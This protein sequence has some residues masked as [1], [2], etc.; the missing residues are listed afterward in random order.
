MS[1]FDEQQF[2]A[3]KVEP[4]NFE[5]LP[6]G[7]YKVLIEKAEEKLTKNKD[8]V[9]LNLKLKVVEGKF[10]N[11]TVF[12]NINLKNKSQAAQAI[13]HGQLSSLCRACGIMTPKKAFEFCNK[14]IKVMLKCVPNQA[15]SGLVNN[16]SSY[17]PLGSAPIVTEP[18]QAQAAPITSA[19]WAAQ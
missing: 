13:G 3:S 11:R 16:V 4:A 6:E 7:E 18:V 14:V 1:F 9:M 15:G 17:L 10:K 5:A 12:S 2:D 19:P 8:G